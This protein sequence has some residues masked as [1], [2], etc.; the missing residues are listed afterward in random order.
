MPRFES[1][2]VVLRIIAKHDSSRGTHH[3]FLLRASEFLN[4]PEARPGRPTSTNR[5]DAA[6][7]LQRR[8]PF[9]MSS[10]ASA[11]QKRPCRQV[12]LC[13]PTLSYPMQKWA[14]DPKGTV[15]S[16]AALMLPPCLRSIACGYGGGGWAQIKDDEVWILDTWNVE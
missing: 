7:R 5:F 14:Q 6:G 1:F 12:Q 2:Q 10:A 8:M 16:A 9:S 15:Q 11:M 13:S 4:W 3:T